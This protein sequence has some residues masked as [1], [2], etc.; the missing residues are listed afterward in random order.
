MLLLTSLSLSASAVRARDH[1]TPE[2]DSV[3]SY[4]FDDDQ[5]LGDGVAPNGQLLT[6]RTRGARESL[7]QARLHFVK[8]LCHSIED[9]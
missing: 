3:T 8:E 6:A 1:E 4:D 7:V 9:L 5:V 2:A